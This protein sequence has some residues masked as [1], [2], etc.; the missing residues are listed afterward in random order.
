MTMEKYFFLGSNIL[1]QT[2]FAVADDDT[3]MAHEWALELSDRTSVPFSFTMKSYLD[4]N[5]E[6]EVS[7]DLSGIQHLWSD[8]LPN[9]SAW[10][11]MSKKMKQLINQHLTGAEG[12]I[13]MTVMVK[14]EKQKIEFYIPRFERKLD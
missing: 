8:Y 10:P 2:A 9:D 11:I 1:P 7:D 13:W 4:G 14:A 3:K 12:I 6:T 5:D